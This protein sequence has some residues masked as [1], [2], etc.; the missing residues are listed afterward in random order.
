ML[1]D[2]YFVVRTLPN[3]SKHRISDLLSLAAA[4]ASCDRLNGDS[5]NPE[6]SVHPV[7]RG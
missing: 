7:Q 6:F 1:T 2:L 4:E 3:G 5:Q